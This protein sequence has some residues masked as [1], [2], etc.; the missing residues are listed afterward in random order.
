MNISLSKYYNDPK[1]NK[2]TSKSQIARIITEKWVEDNLYCPKCGRPL[3]K[4]NDNTPVYDFYCDHSDEI[5][6][7]Q[8]FNRENFQLKSQSKPISNRVIGAEYNKTIQSLKNGNFPSLILLSYDIKTH[9]VTE[10]IFVNRMAI[11]KSSIK[12]RK[13][14]SENAK[15]SN[16]QGCY[17]DLKAIPKIGFIWVIKNNSI[18]KKDYVMKEWERV[19]SV[20]QGSFTKRTWIS[21]II[22]CLDILPEKFTLKDVYKKC[23]KHLSK[24]HPNN[25]HIKEKIRQQL[26][27]LRNKNFIIFDGSGV[28]SKIQ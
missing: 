11:T 8:I 9:Q 17:I 5:I 22:K 23:E 20:L 24:L 19:S 4:Y 18:R 6:T 13:P 21:D 26:Q 25:K 7:N 14:L 3:K 28:Y 12:P 15:R 16:W 2:Y 27:I 10:V 1:L